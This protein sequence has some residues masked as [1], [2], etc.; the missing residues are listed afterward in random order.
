[1]YDDANAG[2]SPAGSRTPPPR[3]CVRVPLTFASPRDP[4][5]CAAKPRP[6]HRN[7]LLLGEGPND[8]DNGM[9]RSVRRPRVC[10][11]LQ[12]HQKKRCSRQWTTRV[13]TVCVILLNVSLR[14]RETCEK[15]ENRPSL[16]ISN[17]TWDALFNFFS[18][19]MGR[20]EEGL[21]EGRGL[22][23]RAQRSSRWPLGWSHRKQTSHLHEHRQRRRRR[24]SA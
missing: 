2:S 17:P 9:M 11:L 23:A 15:C 14:S 12:A 19:R 16:Q 5:W 18:P 1:M 4:S 6:S 8:D 24:A 10:P 20:R 21:E 3:H 13:S 7:A 22:G